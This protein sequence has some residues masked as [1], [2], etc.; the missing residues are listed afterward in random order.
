MFPFGFS[1]LW[2]LILFSSAHFVVMAF[3][4]TLSD[5]L[6]NFVTVC[7]MSLTIFASSWFL[8][9]RPRSMK[10]VNNKIRSLQKNF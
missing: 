2:R 10:A 9:G 6:Q 4:T 5:T 1:F 7:I 3:R 8:A